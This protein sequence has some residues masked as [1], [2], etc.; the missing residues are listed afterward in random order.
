M[1]GEEQLAPAREHGGIVLM[2]FARRLERRVRAAHVAESAR[3]IGFDARVGVARYEVAIA[4]LRF[5]ELAAIERPI[6]REQ[7]RRPIER[8]LDRE[9]GACRREPER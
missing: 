8:V 5:G 7:R 9:R 4:G 3:G 1:R 6:A 2:L